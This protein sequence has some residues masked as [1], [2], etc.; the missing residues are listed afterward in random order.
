[1]RTAILI[2]VNTYE[3]LEDLRSPRADLKALEQVLQANGH[4][5]RVLVL[6]DP[7]RN[8]AMEAL[9]GVLGECRPEDLLCVSFS[10]HGVK[11]S[12]GRL[13]LAFRDTRLKRLL[14]TAISAEV[15]QLMLQD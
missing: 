12:R 13:H 10:G 8:Q 6:P 11:D 4:F 9:E 3:E 2:G 7:T 14:S 5:D 15:L 1:M